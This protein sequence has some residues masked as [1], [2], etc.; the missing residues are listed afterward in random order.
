[1]YL[2]VHEHT[3]SHLHLRNAQ[4]FHTCNKVSSSKPPFFDRSSYQF[5]QKVEQ[6][7]AQDS[8]CNSMLVNPT[9]EA[10][11]PSW[12]EG[13]CSYRRMHIPRPC[14]NCCIS[15][16]F[17][18][19]SPRTSLSRPSPASWV[20]AAGDLPVRGQTCRTFHA[21]TRLSQT[22]CMAGSWRRRSCCCCAGDSSDESLGRLDFEGGLEIDDERI[23][24]RIEG[25]GF[26]VLERIHP[27]ALE[28]FPPWF[29]QDLKNEE[30]EEA[31]IEFWLILRQI[32]IYKKNVC[33]QMQ[34]FN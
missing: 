33:Q 2:L 23:H 9:T 29:V 31:K 6:E 28:D 26:A 7:Q 3:D 18:L 20:V 11:L 14:R 17:A 1:M 21:G 13:K 19:A 27:V 10:L 34:S 8:Q 22:V 25:E 5:H 4:T 15:C 32:E 16:A 24:G 12:H 30:E